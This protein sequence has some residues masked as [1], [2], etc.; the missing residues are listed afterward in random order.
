MGVLSKGRI[1]APTDRRLDGTAR[2]LLATQR[3]AVLAGCTLLGISTVI[4]GFTHSVSAANP[5]GV[6]QAANRATDFWDSGFWVL[7][8]IALVA[9]A[10]AG[11]VQAIGSDLALVN[12]HGKLVGVGAVVPL[13]V[14]CARLNV[15][16]AVKIG[17]GQTRYLPAYGTYLAFLACFFLV[18]W[19]R[20]WSQSKLRRERR[21]LGGI[22]TSEGAYLDPSAI[23]ARPD[24]LE[25]TAMPTAPRSGAAPSGWPAPVPPAGW[26]ADPDDPASLRWWDG[27]AW[28]SYTHRAP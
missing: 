5:L 18:L 19:P 22:V 26:F 11:A 21:S 12:H 17:S 8:P 20:L 2:E 7:C 25:P 16:T 10:V 3:V 13:I 15:F 4:E 14:E 23:W 28:S 1:G 6:L 9:L 27:T 24:R